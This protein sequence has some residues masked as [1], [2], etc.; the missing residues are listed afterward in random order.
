MQYDTEIW[1]EQHH[2]AINVV[3]PPPLPLPKPP[4]LTEHSKG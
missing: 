2:L 1:H 3:I 4:T